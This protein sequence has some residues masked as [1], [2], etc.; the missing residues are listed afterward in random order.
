MF[1]N[2]LSIVFASS[3]QINLHFLENNQSFRLVFHG[4]IIL[5]LKAAKLSLLMFFQF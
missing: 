5:F 1:D 4:N 3:N 2:Q